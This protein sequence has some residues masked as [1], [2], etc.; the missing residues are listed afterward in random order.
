MFHILDEEY[1]IVGKACE[2]L[3]FKVIAHFDDEELEPY[4]VDGFQ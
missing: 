4:F 1:C 2:L 3:V